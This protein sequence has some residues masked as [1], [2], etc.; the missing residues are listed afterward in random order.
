ML[1]RGRYTGPAQK[2]EARDA[3]VEMACEIPVLLSLTHSLF[4]MLQG[5]AVKGFR[6]QEWPIRHLCLKSH[7]PL[8]LC[9]VSQVLWCVCV[10]VYECE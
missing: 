3:F 7:K 9:V 8:L 5:M 1:V 6:V 10:R 2:C 4:C